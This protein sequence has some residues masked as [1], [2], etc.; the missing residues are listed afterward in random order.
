MVDLKLNR[1]LN[2][3]RRLTFDVYHRIY[4]MDL[5]TQPP[6]SIAL[7]NSAIANRPVMNGHLFVDGPA[8]P[9]DF[10]VRRNTDL[11]ASVCSMYSFSIYVLC[12]TI[13][14]TLINV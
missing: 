14:F 13:I 9:S 4:H 8:I 7:R 1:H 3:S 10:Q 2:Q 5:Y 6:F 11:S 12:S